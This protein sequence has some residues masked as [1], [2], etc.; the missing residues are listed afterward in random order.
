MKNLKNLKNHKKLNKKDQ[1]E[2][3]GGFSPKG[4]PTG[5]KGCSISNPCFDGYVCTGPI[6]SHPYGLCVAV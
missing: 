6:P 1:Q 3:R 5:N 2:I 4:I